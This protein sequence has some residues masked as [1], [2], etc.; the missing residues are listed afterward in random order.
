[1]AISAADGLAVLV[2]RDADKLYFA[3]VEREI[4]EL[5]AKAQDNTL[6]IDELQGGS[7]SITN[8]GIFGSMLSTLILKAPQVGI[9]GMH[10]I[11]KRAAVMPD[12]YIEVRQMM[13]LALSYDNRIDDGKEEVQFLVR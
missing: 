7:F 12:D 11:V 8:G 9:L 5:G 13:Y 1:I 2:C 3:G 6:V 4:A 10:N